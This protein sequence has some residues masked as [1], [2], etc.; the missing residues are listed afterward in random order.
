MKAYRASRAA[1]QSDADLA[2]L[3]ASLV[4]CVLGTLLMI[5]NASLILGYDRL[6]WVLAGF[7]AA[8][9]HLDPAPERRVTAKAGSG[10]HW[11]PA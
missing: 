10:G 4:A 11:E 6:F 8:Y 3:G 7:C 5:E 1:M 9:A 2:F